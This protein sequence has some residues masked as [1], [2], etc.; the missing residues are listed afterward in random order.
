M[1]ETRKKTH[2]AIHCAVCAVQGKQEEA[3]TVIN[4]SACCERHVALVS[5]PG[6]SIFQLQVAADGDAV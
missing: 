1:A 2:I 5:K 6:F 4:S 3:F